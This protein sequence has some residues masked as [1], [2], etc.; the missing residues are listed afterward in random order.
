MV[1]LFSIGLRLAVGGLFLYGGTNFLSK[2]GLA[3]GNGTKAIQWGTVG[4]G[5]YTAAKYFKVIK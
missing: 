3:L 5:L 2:L 1:G 4:F